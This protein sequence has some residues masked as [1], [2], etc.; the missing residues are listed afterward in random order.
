MC[1]KIFIPEEI[2]VH[3]TIREMIS[4]GGVE[5]STRYSER[6]TQE[7]NNRD[8]W[9]RWGEA[10]YYNYRGHSDVGPSPASE[11]SVCD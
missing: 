9:R 5:A 1:N 8:S 10:D 3:G 4:I 6:A 2:Q 11:F 7:G